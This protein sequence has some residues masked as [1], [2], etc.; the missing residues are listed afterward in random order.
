MNELRLTV[1]QFVRLMVQVDETLAAR[2]NT[3]AESIK[4]AW[5]DIWLDID[6]RL[7]ELG[8]KDPDGFAS[9]MMDQE[10]VL[11]GLTPPLR[12]AIAGE[13]SKVVQAMQAT[14]RSTG[15]K[16]AKDDLTFEIQE[17][18]DVLSDLGQKRQ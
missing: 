9:M 3:A 18:N 10:V 7:E 15:D 11:T 12:A 6:A 5:D 4:E 13:L 1:W 14:R 8:R 17:L 16:Q 2:P